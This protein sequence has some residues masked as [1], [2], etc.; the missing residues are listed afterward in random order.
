MKKVLLLLVLLLL[1]GCEPNEIENPNNGNNE[2]ERTIDVTEEVLLKNTP[3]ETNAY[4]FTT[5]IEGPRVA[6]VGGIHGDEVAGYLAAESFIDENNFIG[7]VLLIPRANFLATYLVQRYPG[8]NNGGVYNEVKYSDLNR[9]MPGDK[10]GSVTAQIAYELYQ[11]I[12]DFNPDYLI[13]M[14]ESLRSYA[15]LNPRL[16]NSII[17]ENGKSALVVMML[18][19]QYNKNYL[20]DGDLPFIYDNAP[21]QGSFNYHFGKIEDLY[22]FTIETNRQL[23]LEKR[24]IEQKN[25]VKTFFELIKEGRI[26]WDKKL[27]Y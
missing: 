11:T 5:N 13:D 24:V 19:E 6:L 9:A 20:N 23:A 4:Y 25:I 10:N 1:V 17:Y 22:T 14:H 8:I 15:D 21:P 12:M 2:I 27:K 18:V 16:G 26:K 3:Y 7:T